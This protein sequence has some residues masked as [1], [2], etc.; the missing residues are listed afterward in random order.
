MWLL[1]ALFAVL[2]IS[3]IQM[4]IS[5]NLSNIGFTSSG[6]E[7]AETQTKTI[8]D[9]IKGVYGGTAAGPADFSTISNQNAIKAG[10]V[11]ASMT[12]GDGSTIVGAW[13]SQVSLLPS[14]NGQTF[15]VNW[16]SIPSSACAKF[17]ISQAVNGV[18]INGNWVPK[19]GTGFAAAVAAQCN[20]G[21]GSFS[22][23]M[24]S[25]VMNYN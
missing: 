23:V 8:A 10:A 19:T 24:F 20:Q 2:I 3:A 14:G 22:A 13:N 15:Y 18:T 6:V 16:P 5:G 1:G 11:P 17:G 7:V 4:G 25:F 9:N 21:T 12:T